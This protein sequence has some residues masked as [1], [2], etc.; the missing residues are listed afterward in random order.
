VKTVAQIRGSPI[1]VSATGIHG[2]LVG[3]HLVGRFPALAV[4]STRWCIP[5]PGRLQ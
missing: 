5:R 3:G 4:P 2:S 1:A